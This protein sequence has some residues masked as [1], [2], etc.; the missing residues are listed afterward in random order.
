MRPCAGSR[1]VAVLDFSREVG[2]PLDLGAGVALGAEVRRRALGAE[3]AAV[4]LAS[5]PMI[6]LV[7]RVLGV[8]RVRRVFIVLYFFT[9]F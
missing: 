9:I 7:P 8:R 3:A 5:R 1:G 6:V 4:P 2:E